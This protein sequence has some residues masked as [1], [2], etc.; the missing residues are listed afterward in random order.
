[1]ARI[2]QMQEQSARTKDAKDQESVSELQKRLWI[3][4]LPENAAPVIYIDQDSQSASAAEDFVNLRIELFKQ[5]NAAF[6]ASSDYRKIIW[7]TMPATAALKTPDD[8]VRLALSFSVFFAPPN[9]VAEIPAWI[10]S[11]PLAVE[12]LRNS[13]D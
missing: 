8:A 11:L 1:M 6:S 5:F 12:A 4:L 3:T 10:A 13:L 2:G 9:R 7:T